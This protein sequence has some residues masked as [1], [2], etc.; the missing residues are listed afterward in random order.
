VDD[1]IARAERAGVDF[2]RVQDSR[3]VAV[4]AAQIGLLPAI[5]LEEISEDVEL[6]RQRETVAE[7]ASFGEDRE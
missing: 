5:E 7:K 1:L 6:D 3:Q 4:H 2:L